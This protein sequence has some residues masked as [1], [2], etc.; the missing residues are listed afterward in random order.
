[1][2]VFGVWMWP[3]SVIDQGADRVSALC[4]SIGVTDIYF[5]TKGLAGTASYRSALAPQCSDRDLLAEL[6]DA[7]HERGIRVHAWLTSASD[8]D[9]KQRFPESGRCH[10][11]RGKDKGLISL[12][13]EGYIAYMEQ[14]VRELC[15]RYAIDGLHLDYIRYNH[16]LYGWSEED[17]ARYAAS[18]ADI[19]HLK[20]LMDMTFLGEQNSSCIFDAYRA[21]DPSALALAQARRCDVR[22]FA[23]ALTTCAR[24]ERKELILSA[25]LM[26]EGAYEDTAFAD[27]HYGQS[28]EDAAALYD[29]VLPMA[30]SKAYEKDGSWVRL[31]AEGT[32]KQGVK[33][34][35]GLHAYD[36]GTGP[37]LHED[38]QAL[39][40]A[41]IDG[42]CLFRFGAFAIALR[43]G[44]SLRIIN[45][46]AQPITAVESADGASLLPTGEVILPGAE[47]ILP[48][49]SFSSPLRLFCGEAEA[50]VYLAE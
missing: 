25:A 49:P 11:T 35:M 43:Q 7:A 3:Q 46:L 26:P 16:L 29:A 45:T 44:H 37:S 2:A 28:Y 4:A 23:E 14:I 27:L 39:A 15:S 30:Y 33:N 24:A 5:L 32:L 42:I 10:Y 12:A 8:E 20:K 22:R 13:D 47:A 41:A 6:L 18:G 36:G 17:M 38:I 31:V 34:I 19:A 50:C 40:Y 1:M 9:Y 48:I 21:G